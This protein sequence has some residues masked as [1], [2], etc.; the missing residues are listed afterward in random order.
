MTARVTAL[1][2]ILEGDPR[3]DDI[4]DLITAIRRLRGVADVSIIEN[5][6]ELEL[7]KKKAKLEL[8]RKIYTAL[9]DI[10]T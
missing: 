4:T 8:A 7:T 10:L 5:N 1:T 6:A 2:V 9:E 3:E